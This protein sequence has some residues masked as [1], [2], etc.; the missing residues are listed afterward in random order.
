MKQRKRWCASESRSQSGSRQRKRAEVCNT[1]VCRG[2]I[3]PLWRQSFLLLLPTKLV[4]RNSAL[5]CDT[6]GGQ[7]GRQ[8]DGQMGCR[9]SGSPAHFSA[10]ETEHRYPKYL[11]KVPEPEKDSSKTIHDAME[12]FSEILSFNTFIRSS[13]LYFYFNICPSP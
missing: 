13:W 9:S 4:I 6:G 11:R 1:Q 5:K 2:K 7:T 8:A 3:F 12:S 10:I